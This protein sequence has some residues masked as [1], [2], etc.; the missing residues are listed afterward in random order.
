MYINKLDDIANEYNNIYHRTIKR[1]PARVDDNTCIDFSKEVN[2]RDPKF[3]VG[4]HVRFQNTK[5]ILLKDTPKWSEEF[6]L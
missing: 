1:K 6:F 5:I 4:N 2:E 3:K